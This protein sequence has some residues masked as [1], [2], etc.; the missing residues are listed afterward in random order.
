MSTEL[1]EMKSSK[2]VKRKSG[3]NLLVGEHR[4]NH[5]DDTED[6]ILRASLVLPSGEVL[7][8]DK[9]NKNIKLFDQHFHCTAVLNFDTYPFDICP[10]NRKRSEYYVTEPEQQTVYCIM[11]GNGRICKYKQSRIDEDCRGITCWKSGV[12]ISVMREGFVGTIGL[13]DYNFKIKRKIWETDFCTKLFRAPWYL[14][15]IRDGSQLVISD[16]GNHS[17]ICIDVRTLGTIFVVQNAVLMGPRT[18]AVDTNDNIY[19]IGSHESCHNVVKISPEGN[20]IDV[21]L[22]RNDKLNYPSGLSYDK[23]NNR[24][25]LQRNKDKPTICLYSLE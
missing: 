4:I 12:A 5:L 15:T 17:L 24:L 6:F 22:S 21:L 2:F 18:L 14:D 16:Q 9:A 13:L 11:A 1:R 10:S 3:R 8:L 23:F 25:L 20:K 7:L 19:V